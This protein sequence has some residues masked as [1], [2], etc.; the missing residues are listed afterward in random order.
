MRTTFSSY[1]RSPTGTL[2]IQRICASWNTR[3]RPENFSGSGICSVLRPELV[4]RKLQLITD[5]LGHLAAFRDDSLDE[6]VAD[7]L[8]LAAVERVLERIVLRAIDV[9]E[10][11]VSA[12]ATGE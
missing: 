5:D 6:L 8:R 11:L 3:C 10:H 4:E 7:P 12:L 1:A 2:S 9:N